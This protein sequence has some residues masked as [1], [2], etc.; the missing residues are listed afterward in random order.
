MSE[1]CLLLIAYKMLIKDANSIVFKCFNLI[2]RN[3][4]DKMKRVEKEKVDEKMDK[5]IFI[6]C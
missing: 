6:T 4:L 2:D 3:K 1:K 5:P